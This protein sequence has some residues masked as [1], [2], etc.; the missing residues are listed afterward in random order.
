M[1]SVARHKKGKELLHTTRSTEC[2]PI[3]LLAEGKKI[4]NRKID[5]LV[6]DNTQIAWTGFINYGDS[7]K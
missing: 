3:V 1:I 6:K 2:Q 7:E 5:K 4:V